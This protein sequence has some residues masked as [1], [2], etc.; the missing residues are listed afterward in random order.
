MNRRRALLLLL[1]SALGACAS[2]PRQGYSFDKPFDADKRTIAVEMFDNVS[3]FHGLEVHLTDAVVKEIQRSTPWRVVN[4]PGADTVLSGAISAV[5]IR[6]L[7]T[8]P[9]SG[10][11]QQLAVAVT[12]DF[13]WRDQ[14]TGDVLVSRRGQRAADA[15]VP[16]HGVGERIE[17]SER[18]AVE[19]AAK[20]IVGALRS[21]W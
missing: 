21:G 6:K 18:A 7:A 10:L 15:F 4:G 16:A 13:D 8:A 5:D 17:L 3:Y 12:F 9:V 20:A 2:D 14:R 11:S 19:E 1:L